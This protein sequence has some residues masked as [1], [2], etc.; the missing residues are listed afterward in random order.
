MRSGR[1]VVFACGEK[2]VDGWT[3]DW[4]VRTMLDPLSDVDL[5]PEWAKQ[6]GLT[7]CFIY[8]GPVCSPPSAPGTCSMSVRT[9]SHCNPAMCWSIRL[10]RPVTR[11]STAAV[12]LT[13]DG[14]IMRGD[15]NRLLDAA[16]VPA[17]KIIG[18]GRAGRRWRAIPGPV[19]GGQIGLASGGAALGY[20]LA[21]AH[22][23][24]L[25]RLALPGS[26]PL[27]LLSAAGCQALFNGKL[28]T[29]P[30]GDAHRSAGQD[31]LSPGQ[32]VA[33]WQAQPRRFECRKPFDLFIDPP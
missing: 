31:S 28:Q 5:L 17:E 1:C 16:P 26:T 32:V 11:S 30:F 15:N 23:T 21:D 29:D 24:P 13:P 27:R 4:N 12:A 10:K 33:R 2:V 6:R 22:S 19:R 20:A 25:P 18:T 3:S 8:S 9:P 14:W 7:A